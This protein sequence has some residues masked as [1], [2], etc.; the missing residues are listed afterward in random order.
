[1][2]RGSYLLALAALLMAM[3]ILGFGVAVSSGFQSEGCRFAAEPGLRWSAAR[4]WFVVAG[5]TGA[6]FMGLLA[7]MCAVIK[8]RLKLE[9]SPRDVLWFGVALFVGFAVVSTYQAATCDLAA[10]W[11]KVLVPV[12]LAGFLGA[13]IR[14]AF[15]GLDNR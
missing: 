6:G 13:V 14:R 11:T 10:S 5:I 4:D 9:A 12:L 2:G 15:M 1:M 8:R 7:G 3:A